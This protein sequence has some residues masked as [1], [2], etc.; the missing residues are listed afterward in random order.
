MFNEKISIETIDLNSS[1]QQRFFAT[2]REI[3]NK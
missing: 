2:T 3:K 1:D